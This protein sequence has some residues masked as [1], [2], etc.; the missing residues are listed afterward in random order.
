MTA[1]TSTRPN[2]QKLHDPAGP[3]SSAAPA[4]APPRSQGSGASSTNGSAFD[5]L[6]FT[7]PLFELHIPFKA[8][9]EAVLRNDA[10]AVHSVLRRHA[11][12]TTSIAGASSHVVASVRKGGGGKK[13]KQ[14]GSGNISN[15]N[16]SL[17]LS[18]T[19]AVATLDPNV[20]LRGVGVTAAGTTVLHLACTLNKFAAARALIDHLSVDVNVQ[21]EESGWTPLHRALYHG[22]IGIAMLLLG[23]DDIDPSIPDREGIAPFDLFAKTIPELPI[24]PVAD[25]LLTFG[26]NVNFVLGHSN[27]DDREHPRRV[28]FREEDSPNFAYT[29]HHSFPLI[30]DF[31]MAKMHALLLTTQGLYTWGYGSCGRLGVKSGGKVILT[32]RRISFWPAERTV[33]AV[34]AGRDH[35]V[36]ALDD[37]T[38]YIWG[39]NE[40]GQCGLSMDDADIAQLQRLVHDGAAATHAGGPGAGGGGGGGG[41]TR[42]MHSSEGETHLVAPRPLQVGGLKR[43][44][45]TGV[46]ASKIHTVAYNRTTL[47]TFGLNQGQLG[48]SR[49]S[50]VVQPRKVACLPSDDGIVTVQCTE[51]FTVVLLESGTV[52]LLRQYSARKLGFPVPEPAVL[53]SLA[54][55]GG[56]KVT[57]VT[58]PPTIRH[59]ACNDSKGVAYG[60]AISD[61]GDVYLWNVH[62]TSG[63]V[64]QSMLTAPWC[65]WKAHSRADEAFDVVVGLDG[66]LLLVTER[67]SLH[68]S[69]PCPVAAADETSPAPK[70]S[71]LMLDR[72]RRV[73]CNG[74]GGFAALKS[75]LRF[76]LTPSSSSASSRARRDGGFVADRALGQSST[77]DQVVLRGSSGDISVDA[78]Y[79]LRHAWFQ[80]SLDTDWH[81]N[82]GVLHLDQFDAQ[83]LAA[84]A[85]WMR[86]RQSIE[87][88]FADL[89][90][91]LVIADYLLLDDLKDDVS[92]IVTKCL[93][94]KNVREVLHLAEL[95]HAPDLLKTAADYL[96]ANASYLLRKH[97]D[98]ATHDW[99]V[100]VEALVKDQ[101]EKQ[102][103]TTRNH[104]SALKRLLSFQYY[105][106]V[107]DAKRTTAKTAAA[108]N[109]LVA[110][111]PSIESDQPATTTVDRRKRNRKESLMGPA[112]VPAPATV[113]VSDLAPSAGTDAIAPSASPSPPPHQGSA[114]VTIIVKPAAPFS[115]AAPAVLKLSLVEIQKQEEARK[116]AAA[117]QRAASAAPS[118]TAIP[119]A[120]ASVPPIKKQSQRERKRAQKEV[121]AVLD[122]AASSSA[123]SAPTNVWGKSAVT[124]SATA[125]RS[126]AGGIAPGPNSA[127]TRLTAPSCGPA[128]RAPTMTRTAASI[129][130]G[131]STSSFPALTADK[132][133]V[134]TTSTSS[135]PAIDSGTSS[136]NQRS[137]FLA[138]QN[139]QLQ[140]KNLTSRLKKKPLAQIQIEEAAMAHL[141]A[142]YRAASDFASGEW[143]EIQTVGAAP[144]APAASGLVAGP[145]EFF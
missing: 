118:V 97:A 57:P 141:L 92:K 25:E 10:D 23:R 100:D 33:T 111:E 144:A 123:T 83:Y 82:N 26:S 34:A 47:I 87:L 139:E 1:S 56:W 60:V 11:P 109:H 66:T 102:A 19:G 125:P 81:S 96:L 15:G 90:Q 119:D 140:A 71:T 135:I 40:F 37:G 114:D 122:P 86:D 106:Q 20:R 85:N 21:D 13:G 68:V 113:L 107:P 28:S 121:E 88:P 35:S 63:A 101:Q 137:R 51:R 77:L 117:Q 126:N 84:V 27:G 46:A 54:Q 53:S 45:V 30:K 98:A 5:T 93:N 115:P 14:P 91:L 31:A 22:N 61:T 103:P 136:P 59:I 104:S 143:F 80:A 50:V 73:Y 3:S 36:V 4:A 130:T 9:V 75:N 16:S 24:D 8:L 120:L 44:V 138:I 69:S 7:S 41:K 116:R 32:P 18:A 49:D 58:K 72:V 74:Q 43:E 127:S 42:G 142:Q 145:F 128:A 110:L 67:G 48:H 6:L 134:R 94:N 99:V 64:G 52:W 12:D 79:A 70:W 133:R 108:A 78:G 112:P 62:A 76:E 132:P 39:S 17:P 65:V 124:R 95:H 131:P 89:L 129:M 55:A 2:A 105:L 29:P 38:V